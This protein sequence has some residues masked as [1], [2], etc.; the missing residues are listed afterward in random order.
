MSVE[1]V[2]LFLIALKAMF[3]CAAAAEPSLRS[4]FHSFAGPCQFHFLIAAP[5]HP[6]IG[7]REMPAPALDTR[8]R[9]EKA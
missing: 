4:A 7:R 9:P 6:I 1:A 3:A 2:K 8:S 5:V